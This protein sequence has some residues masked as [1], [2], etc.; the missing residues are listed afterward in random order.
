MSGRVSSSEDYMVCGRRKCLMSYEEEPIKTH[1]ILL[2]TPT[3]YIVLTETKFGNLYITDFAK[4]DYQSLL[5]YV[6]ISNAEITEESL[7]KAGYNKRESADLLFQ[8]TKLPTLEDFFSRTSVAEYR[9]RVY[10]EDDI[11]DY[12][13]LLTN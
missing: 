2:E 6:K 1:K 11:N 10:D 9:Y 5:E 4:L 8:A 3:A 13:K 12:L 7:K